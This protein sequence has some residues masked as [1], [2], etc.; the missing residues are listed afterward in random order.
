M[1]KFLY[2]RKNKET[3]LFFCIE[4]N[5][6]VNTS[7]YI[8]KARSCPHCGSEFNLDHYEI[9]MCLI[10]RPTL[11]GLIFGKEN[12]FIKRASNNVIQI[13]HHRRRIRIKKG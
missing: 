7:K 8:L 13:E 2:E 10:R 3:C 1:N 12:I 11:L 4:E 6:P 9:V 5:K